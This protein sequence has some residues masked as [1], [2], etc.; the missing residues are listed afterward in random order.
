MTETDSKSSSR[1]ASIDFKLSSRDASTGGVRVA[2]LIAQSGHC[3]RREAEAL[4]AEGCV[5]VNGEVITSPATFI[6]D[7]S[8]KINDKL[9]NPKQ[10]TRLWLLHK[11][12]GVL[13]T[14]KDPHNRKTIFDLLPKNMPRTISVGRLDYNTEGLL[15][16]T[17][18][19][20]LA[21]YMELPKNKWIRKYRAR[22]FGKINHERLQKLEKG[23]TVDGTRYGSIK[24]EVEVEKASNSWLKISLE[25]GKNRE[26]RKVM[27]H[28]GLQVN[29]LIRVSFGP[30]KLGQLKVCEVEEVT[31]AMLRSSFSGE[32]KF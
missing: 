32:F 30:F 10:A 23:I 25:E 9:I 16:L 21:R 12:D 14:T 17:T 3:S 15:L 13:T 2:K 28:L 18:S 26:I 4:I 8:V 5:K 27:E 31:K 29:R 20:E 11:P 22:V 1:D 6:T 7:H 19:G 24:V